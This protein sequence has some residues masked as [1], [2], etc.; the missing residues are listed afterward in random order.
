[1]PIHAHPT[2]A[3][4]PGLWIELLASALAVAACAVAAGGLASLVHP[5]RPSEWRVGSRTT[6]PRRVLGATG[7]IVGLLTLAWPHRPAA[8]AMAVAFGALGW[9]AAKDAWARASSAG[10][11][12]PHQAPGAIIQ[13]A[14]SGAGVAAASLAAWRGVPGPLTLV[15]TLG[16]GTATLLAVTVALAV[17]VLTATARDL[18]ASFGSFPRGA[19]S[20]RPETNE[21][22]HRRAVAELLAAGI[23][24]GHPSLWGGNEPP[25]EVASAKGTLL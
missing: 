23:G 8:L 2:A 6:A 13:V 11:R 15:R 4:A 9:A 10:G 14:L 19:A 16:A 5:E 20:R 25:F 1:M 21:A 3:A 17:H 24:P 7:L 12:R 18:P 22:R